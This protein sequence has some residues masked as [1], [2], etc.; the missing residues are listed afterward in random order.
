MTK[1]TRDFDA[2]IRNGIQF[3]LES[4]NTFSLSETSKLQLNSW[5]SSRHD[6]GLFSVGEILHVSL[7]FQHHFTKSNIKLSM[8]FSDIFNTGSLQAYSSTVNGIDQNYRQ[9]E[10]SRNFRISLSYDF[11][12]LYTSPS[13]RDQRGSR[14]PSSA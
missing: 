7:G 9:N 10:S 5:Y 2:T 11:C 3:Y 1:L 8:L 14:M 4:N 6:S 13:P 12:L